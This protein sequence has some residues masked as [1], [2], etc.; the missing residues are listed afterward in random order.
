MLVELLIESRCN[1]SQPMVSRKKELQLEQFWPHACLY[2]TQKT[3]DKYR[4]SD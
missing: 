2:T 4:G 3:K 1:V